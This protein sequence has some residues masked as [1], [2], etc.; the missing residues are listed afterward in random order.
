MCVPTASPKVNFSPKTPTSISI[1]LLPLELENENDIKRHNLITYNGKVIDIE[2]RSVTVSDPKTSQTFLFPINAALIDLLEGV[3]YNIKARIHASL[4]DPYSSFISV[5]TI[6][7][8]PL[9]PSLRIQFDG[10]YTTKLDLSWTPLDLELQNGVITGYLIQYHGLRVDTDE[11]ILTSENRNSEITNLEEGSAYEISIC[12]FTDA[13]MGPCLEVVNRTEEITPG[14]TLQNVSVEVSRSTSI[15]VLWNHLL[16]EEENGI[17]LYYLIIIEGRGS[18]NSVYKKQVNSTATYFMMENL[19]RA[20]VY[21]VCLCAV[22][23]AGN[24]PY[25]EVI[26][27]ET[28]NDPP[29]AAPQGVFGVGSINLIIVLWDPPPQ[30]ERNGVITNYQVTY[31]GMRIDRKVYSS[32]ETALRMI[33]PNLH[34]GETYQLKVL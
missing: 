21:S 8:S 18:D 31:R 20:N 2:E 6:E 13:G 11:R 32:N 15:L 22:N 10:V 29:S 9:G 34:E 17:I 27:V 4:G 12:A 7:P 16:P 24:G 14:Q 33:I 28:Y 3:E 23:N 5:T 30:L 19:Q 26:I 1:L 25:S